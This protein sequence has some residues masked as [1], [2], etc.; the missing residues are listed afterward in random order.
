MAYYQ[1]DAG[2]RALENGSI[3]PITQ[4]FSLAQI[5][6]TK[7]LTGLTWGDDFMQ[8][9]ENEE[10]RK[11]VEELLDSSRLIWKVVDKL[12]SHIRE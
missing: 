7:V 5:A 2:W 3:A 10:T 6:D 8:I 9:P 12:P 1:I 4:L 11:I